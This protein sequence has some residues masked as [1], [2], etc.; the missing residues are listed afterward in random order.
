MFIKH[1]LL[2]LYIFVHKI[3]SGSFIFC[4]N[5]LGKSRFVNK[6]V[7]DF[8]FLYLI[9]FKFIYSA[10]YETNRRKA[11]LQKI[12][13]SILKFLHDILIRGDCQVGVYMAEMD[14]TINMR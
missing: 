1:I 7:A 4:N 6:F 12:K 14:S 5:S 8:K 9:Q 11:A 10:F 3:Y 2:P 13:V